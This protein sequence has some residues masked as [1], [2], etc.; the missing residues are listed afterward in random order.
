MIKFST[1]KAILEIYRDIAKKQPLVSAI[2]G[3]LILAVYILYF[4]TGLDILKP[5]IPSG[6]S[7]EF[8]INI[9]RTEEY[10]LISSNFTIQRISVFT[11]ALS[12]R[13]V[14]VTVRLPEGMEMHDIDS[15]PRVKCSWSKSQFGYDKIIF[16]I[17]CS[18]FN[19]NQD[20]ELIFSATKPIAKEELVIVE[21]MGSKESGQLIG[22]SDT[23]NIWSRQ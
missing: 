4:G 14:K 22:A 16:D 12:L 6:V 21:A 8:D 13:N 23:D 20:V 7:P 19:E 3:V 10:K 18:F 5:F 2:S 11:R 1:V 9:K 17:G 15:D